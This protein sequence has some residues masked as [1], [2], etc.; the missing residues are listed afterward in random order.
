MLRF[1][2]ESILPEYDD[3]G[4]DILGSCEILV[5]A[6]HN[7]PDDTLQAD[8]KGQSIP[9][10]D[11]VTRQCTEERARDVKCIGDGGPTEGFP[12]GSTVSQDNCHPFRGVDVER[13]GREIVDEPDERDNSLFLLVRPLL[14]QTR[15]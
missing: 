3:K 4:C 1:R 7:K 14:N 5:T 6:G 8:A 11:P 2:L 13:I 10:P 15:G 9:G 12:Q